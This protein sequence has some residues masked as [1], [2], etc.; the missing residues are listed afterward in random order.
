MKQLERLLLFQGYRCFFCDQPIPDGEASVE[1][2]VA[3]AN[4]GGNEDDNC[5]ACCRSLNLAFGSKPYKEKLRAIVVHRGQFK[6]PRLSASSGTIAI[7]L[8]VPAEATK[9][10][11]ALV[12]SDL[13]KRGSARPRK[14]TTLRNTI[15]AAFQKQITEDEVSTLVSSLWAKGYIV[16]K[17]TNVSYNL[18]KCV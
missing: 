14:L 5:V 8:T 17:E 11:L 18:P 13:Q 15:S 10:K 7:E 4:G 1:H 3:S 2:L 16:V 6:C 12:V 9:S